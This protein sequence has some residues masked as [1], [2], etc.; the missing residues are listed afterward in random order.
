MPALRL[1][2]LLFAALPLAAQV[3]DRGIAVD[4][5]ATQHARQG[6]T[7]DFSFRLSDT[8]TH[9]PVAGSRP[10]AWLGLRRGAAGPKDCTRLAATY[11]AGDLFARADVD[12][13]SYFVVAMNDDAS[14]SIV[15]PLFGF[16]GSKLLAMVEL[17][18]RG[19]DW[20]L[21]ADQ[22]RLFVSMPE[23]NKVAVVDTRKWEIVH[24]VATGPHPRRVVLADQLFV[25]DDEGVTAIDMKTFAVTR[26]R[27]G[28]GNDLAASD[29]FV[30]ASTDGVVAV[31]DA[32]AAKLVTRVKVAGTPSSLAYSTAAKTVYAIAGDRLMPVWGQ[33]SRAAQKPIPIRPGATQIRFA[34]LGRYAL[35][36]NPERNVVQVLDAATNRIVQNADISDG[37]DQ[38]T[39][40]DLLGYV[41]RRASETILTIPLE[42][43]GAEGR[44]LSVADFPGGQHAYG[45]GPQSIAA[46]IVPSPEGPSVLVANPADKMIYLYKEGMAA[47][48]GGF[49]DYGRQPRAALV[50]DRG[51]RERKPGQYT[52]T[53]AVARPGTY[54]VVFFLDAPRVVACFALTIEPDNR[55][56]PRPL[57]RV[58]AIA[59]PKVLPAGA[60][61]RLR[62]ALTGVTGRERRRAGDVR[63][64]AF[65]APGIWQQRGDAITLADGTYEFE[66]TPPSAGIYYLY[67]ESESLG[68]A[69]NSGQF[70]VYEA[71]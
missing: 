18:S 16:G 62:F 22:S 11:L 25:A 5:A 32:H 29:D 50:V 15:D 60:S 48:A 2:C 65:E 3:V 51:L 33:G 23:A 71:K 36:A 6:E 58:A 41:R 27:V 42:Q 55:T 37:P 67:V 1:A 28:K 12:L 38:I 34:P 7:V 31:I 53:V 43:L 14:L 57:T 17:E 21:T 4:F 69:R 9:A 59:P 35:I 19:E 49:S 54:D 13:N 63:A 40:T 70:L 47:P 46:S 24:S 8:A 30:F 68:L 20:A 26:L 56:P 61:A 39:F 45:D 52:T 66:F 64:L 10:A 44:N